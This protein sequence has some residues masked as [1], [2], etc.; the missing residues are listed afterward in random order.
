MAVVTARS[1]KN[2][3]CLL[4]HIPPRVTIQWE[5][6][7]CCQKTN[8]SS[9]LDFNPRTY[10]QSYTLTVSHSVKGWEWGGG[11][12]DGFPLG[13]C[14]VKICRACAVLYNM[15]HILWVVALLGARDVIKA[16]I[17]DLPKI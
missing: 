1:A 12:V 3:N 15:R 13:F 5:S 16:A 11:G 4:I 9:F 17:L 7:D 6:G 10:K 8:L 2:E 14:S